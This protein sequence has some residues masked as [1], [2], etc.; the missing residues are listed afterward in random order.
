MFKF[1]CYWHKDK[2]C[3]NEN[4]CNGCYMQPPNKNKDNGKKPPVKIKWVRDYDYSTGGLT[5][6][7]PECPSCGEM[8]YSTE[9]CIFCGQRFIQDD[10]IKEYN[11]PAPIV[12]LECPIC[13]GKIV[14]SRSRYNN[15]FHG[16]CES[17]GAVIME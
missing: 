15:H 3:I 7:I 1:K 13:G 17:C 8:P 6:E 10:K 2:D 11:E 4:Y 14:G 9:V 5:G 16:K 12:E